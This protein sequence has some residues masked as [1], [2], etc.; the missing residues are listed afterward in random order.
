MLRLTFDEQF[1]HK[2]LERKD[3]IKK[4]SFRGLKISE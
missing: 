1:E 2:I 3:E 4:P